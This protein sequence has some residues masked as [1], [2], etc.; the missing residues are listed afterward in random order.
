METTSD[1]EEKSVDWMM[2]TV[3]EVEAAVGT[4]RRG[5]PREFDQLLGG[6]EPRIWR[7]FAAFLEALS[8]RRRARFQEAGPHGS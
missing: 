1:S 3:E 5:S 4:F 6:G 7:L 8:R 2:P